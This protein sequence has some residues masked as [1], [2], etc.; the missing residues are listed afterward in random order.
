MSSEDLTSTALT[1]C[2]CV[3]VLMKACSVERADFL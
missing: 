3:T 2:L 1:V